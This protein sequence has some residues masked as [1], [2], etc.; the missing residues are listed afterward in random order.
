[1]EKQLTPGSSMILEI[2]ELLENARKKCCTA[3]QYTAF[4][5][6]LEHWPDHR[7]V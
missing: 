5:N 4:D 3:G 7:R 6:L 1:M 2:R